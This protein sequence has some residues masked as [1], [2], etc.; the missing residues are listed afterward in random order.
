MTG[1]HAAA[2]VL[3]SAGSAA[4]LLAGAAFARLP[5]RLLRLHALA[6]ASTLGG[7]LTAVAVAVD[8]GP[9]RAAL[10]LLLIGAL[11]LAAGPVT[12]MAVGRLTVRQERERPR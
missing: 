4:L 8:T 7:P 2:L 12:T 10:K 11:V 5:G 9:G 1:R 6:V 3:L